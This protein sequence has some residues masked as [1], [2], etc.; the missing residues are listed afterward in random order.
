M[1]AVYDLFQACFPNFRFSV[2]FQPCHKTVSS[3]DAILVK[4]SAKAPASLN[5]TYGGLSLRRASG[6]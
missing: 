4:T 2:L 6:Q 3:P 5:M 1:I